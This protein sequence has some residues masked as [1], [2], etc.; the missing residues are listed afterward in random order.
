MKKIILILLTALSFSF[1]ASAQNMGTVTSGGVTASYLYAS[2][3]QATKMGSFQFNVTRVSSAIN[4][5]ILLQC[6]NDGTNWI[7]PSA[8][9]T[10]HISNSATQQLMYNVP[11]STGLTY[12]KYRFK[13][14]QLSGDTATVAGYFYGRQ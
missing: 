9:D 3:L 12:L 7:T 13:C 1:V 4:G 14:L 6:S 10:L 8:A 2:P 11:A 5:S